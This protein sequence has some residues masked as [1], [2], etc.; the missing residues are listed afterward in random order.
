MVCAPGHRQIIFHTVRWLRA[1]VLF[2]F[3][4]GPCVRACV[5]GWVGIVCVVVFVVVTRPPGQPQ[6][7]FGR[8]ISTSGG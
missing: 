3:V 6:D 2:C 5:G 1:C 8:L 4:L 7:V